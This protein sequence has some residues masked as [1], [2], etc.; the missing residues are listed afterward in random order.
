MYNGH[1]KVNIKSMPRVVK[2]ERQGNTMQKQAQP[3]EPVAVVGTGVLKNGNGFYL[4]PSESDPTR[5]YVVE[6]HPT[7]LNCTCKDHF[8]RGRRCKHIAAV[9]AHKTRLQYEQAQ[10]QMAEMT[11]ILRQVNVGLDELDRR[12][13]ARMSASRVAGSHV[14][15]T[16]LLR[17]NNRPFSLMK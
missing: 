3:A 6:Q 16:A 9:V 14:G 12:E 7:H 2:R 4:V 5:Y 13:M 8:Y 17:R 15:D 1:Y 11:R 10:A